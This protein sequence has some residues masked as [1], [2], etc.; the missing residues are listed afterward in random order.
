MPTKVEFYTSEDN[1]NFK[2]VKTI[3]NKL[4]ARNTQ[5][6]I[7]DFEIVITETTAKFVKVRAYNFGKLPEWHQGA[8]GEAFIFIDEVTVK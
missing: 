8:G 5:V 7:A 2:L 4:D 3:E 1:G 6:Q